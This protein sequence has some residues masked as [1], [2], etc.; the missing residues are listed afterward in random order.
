MTRLLVNLAKFRALSA[1]QQRIVV[2]AAFLLP[3]I[4]IG[5][6]LFGLGRLQ[7][8]RQH[9]PRPAATTLALDAIMAMGNLVNIAGRH[10]LCP[11][12]C[13]TRSLLLD[14]LLRRRGVASQLRIGVRLAQGVLDAHAWVEVAGVPVNDRPD[15]DEQFAAFAEALPLAA[16]R[17][18]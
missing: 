4:W 11:V 16:F 14:A 12:T 8:W 13:L 2:Q 5:L 6:Q 18:P 9:P 10:A 17:S 3:C 7:R 15:V 1:A